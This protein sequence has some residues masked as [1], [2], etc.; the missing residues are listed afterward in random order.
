LA[1]GA[2]HGTNARSARLVSGEADP[3]S[4]VTDN[5]GGC[6]LPDP[7]TRRLSVAGTNMP[8]HLAGRT[9]NGAP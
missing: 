2:L 1:Q 9:K 7:S 6:G 3:L 5:A 8:W 4:D